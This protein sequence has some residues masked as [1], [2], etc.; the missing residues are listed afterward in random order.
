MCC[1]RPMPSRAGPLPSSGSS[2]ARPAVAIKSARPGAGHRPQNPRRR[3][4]P[5]QPGMLM[6]PWNP[7]LIKHRSSLHEPAASSSRTEHRGEQGGCLM[8][9]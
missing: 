7:A 1:N 9:F 3:H 8:T 6:Q 5:D 2:V 4:L